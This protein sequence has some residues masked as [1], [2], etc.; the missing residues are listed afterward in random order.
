ML[1][2]RMGLKYF[3]A[4]AVVELVDVAELER[5]VF[6]PVLHVLRYPRERLGQTLERIGGDMER[7]RWMSPTEA[8]DYGLVDKVLERRG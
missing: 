7:D 2:L 4:P 6:G 5:E 1:P 3:V 8:L